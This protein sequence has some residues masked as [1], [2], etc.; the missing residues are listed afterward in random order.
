MDSTPGIRDED[1]SSSIDKV[2]HMLAA[3]QTSDDVYTKELNDRTSSNVAPYIG[4][5]FGS[6]D[7]AKDEYFRYAARRGFLVRKCSTKVVDGRLVL[8]RFVSSREVWC[9]KSKVG[10]DLARKSKRKV[11]ETCCG[12]D[13]FIRIN[14]I[15]DIGK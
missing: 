5:I 9:R 6:Y 10:F 4:Q 8:R 13:A 7:E 11:R 2:N 1:R 12:C 3:S 14:L 15:E